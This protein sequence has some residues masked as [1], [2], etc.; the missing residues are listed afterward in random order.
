M[1]S[2]IAVSLLLQTLI[3]INKRTKF[4]E[5]PLTEK[6]SSNDTEKRLFFKSLT[7]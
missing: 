5:K 1:D 3:Y 6:V 4:G 2:I 7:D